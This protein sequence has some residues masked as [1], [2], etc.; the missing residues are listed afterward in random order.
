MLLE[1][2]VDRTEVGAH[3]GPRRG[4]EATR[5]KHRTLVGSVGAALESLIPT[6]QRH[7]M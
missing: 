1:V 4:Q 5:I 6:Q 2:E 3:R 7:L